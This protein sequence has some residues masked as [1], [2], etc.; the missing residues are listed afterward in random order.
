VKWGLFVTVTPKYLNFAVLVLR[1][2]IDSV[3]LSGDNFLSLQ[4][5]PSAQII[6][7]NTYST[8]RQME[9][10]SIEV[11]DTVLRQWKVC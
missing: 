4:R 10:F 5:L 11:G 2:I 9:I 8:L 7:S 3:V 6:T 1:N